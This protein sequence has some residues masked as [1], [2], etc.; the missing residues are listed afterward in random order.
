[1]LDSDE[2]FLDLRTQVRRLT[3]RLTLTDS[4]EVASDQV[5]S[6]LTSELVP[7]L[8]F[9]LSPDELSD[10]VDHILAYAKQGACPG[11]DVWVTYQHR[12]S[13]DVRE[14]VAGLETDASRQKARAWLRSF[15]RTLPKCKAI[16]ANGERCTRL[17]DL[18]LCSQ[19]ARQEHRAK[20]RTELGPYA[21][22]T[23]PKPKP[24]NGLRRTRTR[25]A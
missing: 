12:F 24:K 20:V 7:R 1:M 4:Q 11:Q 16:T 17:T 18:G 5:A 14:F 13:S 23:K 25:A 15:T 19:H 8:V 2:Q 10:A 9:E 3:N 6:D 21:K 22:R